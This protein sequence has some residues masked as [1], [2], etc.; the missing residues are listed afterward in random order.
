MTEDRCVMCGAIIPEGRQVCWI[1]ERKVHERKSD[2]DKKISP[3]V[4]RHGMEGTDCMES[5]TGMQ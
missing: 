1:C 5:D 4:S 3:K 2:P